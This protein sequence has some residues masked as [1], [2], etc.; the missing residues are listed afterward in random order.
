MLNLT[1]ASSLELLREGMKGLISFHPDIAVVGEY[2]RASE[3]CARDFYH[4]DEIMVFADPLIDLTEELFS[5]INVRFSP[6]R[7]ILIAR[8]DGMPALLDV[9]K[10]SA[11]GLLSVDSAASCFVDA[12]RTVGAGRAYVS[13]EMLCM[14]TQ[15]GKMAHAANIKENLSSR[16]FEILIRIVQGR[17]NVAIG[18]ELE[19][20]SK[21][22]S[23]HKTRLMGKLGL[24]SVPE[25]VQYAL[26]QGL[27]CMPKLGD[28]QSLAPSKYDPKY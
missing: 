12:I 18:S 7:V 24:N 6:R 16:E 11:R 20:S 28:E 9:V 23:T 22:V 14:F 19:I 2:S 25:L 4:K 5:E 15:D 26:Q 27:I 8:P 10:S 1:L 3:I 17:N 13:V 21:T